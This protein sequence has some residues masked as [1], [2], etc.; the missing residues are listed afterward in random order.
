[1]ILQVD[2]VQGIGERFQRLFPLLRFQLALPYRDAVPT[3]CRQ[4]P[5][6]LPVTLHVPADLRHPELPVRLR[7][8]TA[9]RILNHIF[10]PTSY[11]RHLWQR[12]IVSM[13]EASVHE[14]A[15]PVF[16]QYQ[17]RMPRQPLMVQPVTE[18]SLPQTTT[19]NHFWLRVLAS[20]RCHVGVPLLCREFIHITSK[21]L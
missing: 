13:P 17:V 16:S 9:L 7:N 4:F 12:H 10:H 8:L 5:V 21:H 15:C 20:N 3:H 11:I 18:P 19:H 6:I 14:D 2:M 1:M